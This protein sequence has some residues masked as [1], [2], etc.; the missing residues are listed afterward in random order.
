MTSAAK[1]FPAAA[2]ILGAGKGT[3]MKS[4]HPKVMHKVASLSMIGHVIKAVTQINADKA[5]VVV[6]PNMEMVEAEVAPHQTVI[7]HNQAG[8]GD[9]VKAALPLMKDF[10]QG[11]VL[12]LFGD[13]P[14]IQPETLQSMISLREEGNAVVV[15]GFDADNPTGYGR[16]ISNAEG[17]LTAI[18]EQKD[19]SPEELKVNVC[20][21]GVMAIDAEHLEELLLAIDNNNASGEYY[22]T[23]VVKLACDR[24]LE[25]AVITT[26]EDQVM[27]VNSRANLA[28]AE[29]VWQEKRRRVAMDEGVTLIDPDTVFFAHDTVIGRDVVIGPNVFFGP[30]VRVADDVEIKAFSHLEGA[31][32]GTAAQVGPYARLRPGAELQEAAFVGNFVEVKNTVMGE[33]AKASHLT[34]L[35]DSEIGAG[36]NIGAGTIT[37]NYDGFNKAKTILGENVFIGSN[38]ALVAPVTIEKDAMV[39]AGSVITKDVSAE[40]MAFAR[41]PQKEKEGMATKF[42]ELAKKKKEAAKAAQKKD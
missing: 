35:G 30:K 42:R 24:D 40:S 5:V 36:S 23:D 3:R 39:S 19:A 13:T 27:G 26:D 9:A 6:G 37:C 4:K 22:L 29:K 14:F 17:K 25:C 21:S 20:N 11:T 31:T 38:S 33:G 28:H 15:L 7:Q 32:V 18:V 10:K 34:Y 12:I 2:I 1:Q 16:L 8:T 41:S